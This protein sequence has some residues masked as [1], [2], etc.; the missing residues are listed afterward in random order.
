METRWGAL[1]L[2]WQ[3]QDILPYFHLGYIK[4]GLMKNQDF[5][6]TQY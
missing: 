1:T 5:T 6:T 2:I 3:L 4:V